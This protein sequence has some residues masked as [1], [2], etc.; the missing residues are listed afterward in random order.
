VLVQEQ[1]ILGNAKTIWL[2]L[3]RQLAK[4]E[5][6]SP[7]NLELDGPRM[8]GGG[9]RSSPGFDRDRNRTSCFLYE[10]VDPNPDPLDTDYHEQFINTPRWYDGTIGN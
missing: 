1:W 8:A 5:V 7:L 2:L 4:D 9:S 3:G 10:V 6:E